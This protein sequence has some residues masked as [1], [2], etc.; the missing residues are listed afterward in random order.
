MTTPLSAV[1]GAPFVGRFT[2]LSLAKALLREAKQDRPSVLMIGGE[3]GVGKTRL[4]AEIAAA[5]K[6]M[7]FLIVPARIQSDDPTVMAG[8]TQVTRGLLLA[9]G[10]E[11]LRAAMVGLPAA[12]AGF[13]PVLGQYRDPRA[14]EPGA[15]PDPAAERLR[16]YQGTRILM[17]R[18]CATQPTLWLIDDLHNARDGE[19]ALFAF[20]ARTLSSWD[21]D[22][23]RRLPLLAVATHRLPL[24]DGTLARLTASAESEGFPFETIRLPPLAERDTFELA[25]GIVN[26]FPESLRGELFRKTGGNPFF[27]TEALA[28]GADG[29]APDPRLPEIPDEVRGLIRARLAR[30]DDKARQTCFAA[31][32]LGE[33]FT[34]DLLRS[35]VVMPMG[36]LLTT[37]GKLVEENILERDHV[38]RTFR[39]THSFV[40]DAIYGLAPA[41]VRQQSHQAAA[42][43]LEAELLDSGRYAQLAYHYGLSGERERE[44]RN[45]LRAAGEALSRYDGRE[46]LGAYERLL[47]AYATLDDGDKTK[48]RDLRARALSGLVKSARMVADTERAVSAAHELLGVARKEKDPAMIAGA[49]RDLAEVLSD[50]NES[51]QALAHLDEAVRLARDMGDK[52]EQAR[53][54]VIKSTISQRLGSP[55]TL[56]LVK[57]SIKLAREAGDADLEAEALVREAIGLF[58][59]GQDR[60][61]EQSYTRALR[62]ARQRRLP[63]LVAVARTAKGAVLAQRASYEE[64]L[65]EFNQALIINKRI[66]DVRATGHSLVN[67]A[68]IHAVRG[69]YDR[70]IE[71]HKK[72]IVILKGLGFRGDLA[73]SIFAIGNI[74][75]DRRRYSQA[76][77]HFSEALAIRKELGERNRIAELMNNIGITYF[78]MGDYTKAREHLEV[79]MALCLEMNY[80]YLGVESHMYLGAVTAVTGDPEAGIGEIRRALEDARGHDLPAQALIARHL[81]GFVLAGQ[82]HIA[83]GVAEIEG[84]I[85]EANK[86]GLHPYA[87]RFQ[88]T[89][90]EIQGDASQA[91]ARLEEESEEEA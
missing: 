46:A 43:A 90:H 74:E 72:A 84:A 18:L 88:R 58:E 26:G 82:G 79:S 65:K 13:L 66:G 83:E 28:A 61:A 85:A 22:D 57:E 2:E 10:E 62:I 47:E 33:R 51:S 29:R 64:A 27:V 81:I 54:M 50:A 23:E 68:A 45:L 49:L 17:G 1:P 48:L 32:T 55:G 34:L 38:D 36:E 11:R 21:G 24:G 56:A 87:E 76:L 14:E 77:E 35:M 59:G 8:M 75:Y 44:I 16:L 73:Y 25:R 42:Q 20:L 67:L 63:R 69:R 5:A 91:D 39:F 80:V 40:K 31:A 9:V 71:L 60:A 12:L 41:P 89:L 86:L 70:A 78:D 15:L 4:L 3:D 30:F 37:V 53:T 19:L 7:G 52:G 6:R